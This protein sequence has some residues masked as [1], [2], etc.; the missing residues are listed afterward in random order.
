[1]PTKVL[2]AALLLFSASAFAQ[3]S[4]DEE[5]HTRMITPDQE[6]QYLNQFWS[7]FATSRFRFPQTTW[8]ECSEAI[9]GN[10]NG[11]ACSD[12]RAISVIL[13]K[14]IGENIY[15]C[16]NKGLA[17]QGGGSVKE[18]HIVHNG[19]TGDAEHSPRS[20]HAENRAI[21]IVR[22]EM[23]LTNGNVKK[24]VYEGTANRAFYTAF[25]KCWGN[26]VMEKNGCPAYGSYTAT[27][28]WENADHRHHLHVSVPYCVNGRY[29]TSYYIK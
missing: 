16:V 8:G 29:N 20:L 26:V 12:K 1:M 7:I 21:D 23:K 27:I 3:L 2:L 13:K 4:G 11:Y 15:S 19:I 28:G 17:A 25:R 24:F 18:L 6:E 14:F 9:T 5:N 22:L 10:Y